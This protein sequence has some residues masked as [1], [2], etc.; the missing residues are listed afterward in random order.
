VCVRERE[1]EREREG[2]QGLQDASH[3]QVK[4]GEELKTETK[5]ESS[6]ECFLWNTAYQLAQ[7]PSSPGQPA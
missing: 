2:I 4:P 1:R 6:E 5:A 7:L 3:D